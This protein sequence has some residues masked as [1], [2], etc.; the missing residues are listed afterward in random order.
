MR[1]SILFLT[2]WLLS[3]L[4]V[5]GQ[6]NSD[7][8]GKRNEDKAK[9][10]S[11]IESA[12]KS[13]KIDVAQALEY[14]EQA[15]NISEKLE[16][17]ELIA[18]SLLELTFACYDASNIQKSIEYG[19]LCES[20]FEKKNDQKILAALYNSLSASYFYIGDSEMTDFYSDKCIEIAEKN[21]IWDVLNKQYYNRGTIL[22][23][24]GDFSRS[25]DYAFKALNV[26]KKNNNPAYTA[27]CYDL[28]GV[29]SQRMNIHRNAIEYYERS[30]QIYMAD[31]NKESLGYNYSNAAESYRTI[32]ILDSAFLYYRNSLNIFKETGS[33]HGMSTAYSGLAKCHKEE[34]EY[35]SA[36]IYI[37]KCLKIGLLSEMQ[38]DLAFFYFEA[39]EVAYLQNY[40]KK[41]LNYLFKSL[42][43]AR[44]NGFKEI[45]LSVLKLVSMTYAALQKNDSAYLYLSRSVSLNDSLNKA[46]DIRQRAYLMAEHNVKDRLEH[47]MKSE[48]QKRELWYIIIGLCLA[49]ILIL[50]ILSRK[51]FIRNNQIQTINSELE[52]YKYDLEEVLKN[53]T[54]ELVLSE[55]QVF[56]LSNNLP[57]GAIFRIAFENEREGKTLFVSSG[58]EELTGQSIGTVGDF[59]LFFQNKIHPDDSRELLNKLNHA[60]HNRSGLDM[61]YRFYKNNTDMRWFHV[62]AI[63]VAGDDGLTY[64]D[65]YQV[66][67]TDQKYFEQ[68]LVTAKEKAEESDKLKSAFLANMSHEI[69]TP[70]NAIIGFSSLLSGCR[71]PPHRLSTYLDLIQENCQSLLRLIDD[72][73]DI[74]KIEAEQLTFRPEVCRVADIMKMIREYFEPIIESKYPSIE[75]WIDESSE[76]TTLTIYI[77]IFR[78]KQIFMN[79]IENALKFTPKGF[80]RCGHILDSPDSV[81]FYVTAITN[82][83]HFS[84]FFQMHL[85][86]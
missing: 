1:I 53:R 34:A 75:L 17:E 28:M 24:R 18:R 10:E 52:K 36:R 66:D 79:L 15:L 44:R 8:S 55:Q 48:K 14:A 20:F 40:Y 41:A 13:Q 76:N 69:R 72:I 54:R 57:N 77:D 86:L 62:R 5:T 23:Y 83:F 3:S 61:I 60:I 67:E 26:A 82:F 35:D 65:G 51:L 27:A 78:L 74:S 85:D 46:D 37:E 50:S 9:A 39:G 58:W 7:L 73:V 47:E 49:V 45:E 25:M 32:N 59:M 6:N 38:K 64:L 12:Q 22:F 21:E 2:L 29:L 31:N 63:A 16:N 80:V 81:H 11:L 70:M 4:S 33:S 42:P 43:M 71:L 56:N 19:K 84:I 30:R 68:E